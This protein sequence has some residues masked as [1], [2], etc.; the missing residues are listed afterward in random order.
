[1]S[2][3]SLWTTKIADGI[4]AAI[5]AENE[6]D[7]LDLLKEELFRVGVQPPK[8]IRWRVMATHL[9]SVRIIDCRK[10]EVRHHGKASPK[11]KE[12]DKHRKTNRPKDNQL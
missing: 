2:I 7:A 5:V 4:A 11:N 9:P 8:E 10:K 12:K 1:V 3:M 6:Q